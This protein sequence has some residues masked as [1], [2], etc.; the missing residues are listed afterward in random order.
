MFAELSKHDP[1]LLCALRGPR[2]RGRPGYDPE[3]L[4][5]CYVA[6]YLLGLP[7]VSELIRRLH[8]NPY[9]AEACGIESPDSIPSQPTFS[10]FFARLSKRHMVGQLNHVFHLITRRFYRTLPGFGKS[11][12]LDSTDIK[13]WS[14]GAHKKPTDKHAGWI[15]K[16]DTNGRGKFTWGYKVSLLV[17]TTHELPLALNV[18]SGNHNDLRAASVLLSQ[19]RWITSMF[20]PQ[21]VIADAGYSSED[22]RHLIR[23]QYRGI[24]IV[25][26]NSSHKRAIQKYP[27][28]DKWQVTYDRR[29]AVERVF[30][31]LKANRKLNSLR[32]RGIYKVKAHCLLSVMA[33]QVHA[34]AT[35]RRAAVRRLVGARWPTKELGNRQLRRDELW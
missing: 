16:A 35:N 7:S 4:W 25:K 18:M 32:V 23:R 8:D 22:F 24:P 6:Y 1:E 34:L 15:V 31:R 17:D 19:A 20:H 5:H 30:S 21:Y 28:D 26:T 11:V 33:L 29:T 14:N 2:R 3:I 9:V 12:A 10:R 27:E 13:A